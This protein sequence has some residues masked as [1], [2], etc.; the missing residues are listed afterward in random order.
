MQRKTDNL[1]E[2]WQVLCCFCCVASS[3]AETKTSPKLLTWAPQTT[4]CTESGGEN[5]IY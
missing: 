1:P 4:I 2:Q 3:R 5:L